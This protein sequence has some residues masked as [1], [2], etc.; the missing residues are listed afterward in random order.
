MLEGDKGIWGSTCLRLVI[1]EALRKVQQPL[2]DAVPWSSIVT[3]INEEVH[4][5][6]S[7]DRHDRTRGLIV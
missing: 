3:H 6:I 1:Q 7:Q 4:G 2:Q 5:L